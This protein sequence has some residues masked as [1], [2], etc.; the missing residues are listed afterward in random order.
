MDKNRLA[1]IILQ[2]E[3]AG[4][5]FKRDNIRPS[6]LGKDIVGL[7]CVTKRTGQRITTR[8][9]LHGSYRIRRTAQNNQWNVPT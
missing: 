4:I 9:S 3:N 8:L 7:S 6:Q 2:G 1:E 5:E